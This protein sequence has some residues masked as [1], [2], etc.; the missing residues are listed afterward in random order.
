MFTLPPRLIPGDEFIANF[1]KV[2]ESTQF[3]TAFFNSLWLTTLVVLVQA[4]PGVAG[5]LRLR[6]ASFS[7]A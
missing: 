2:L 5:G 3:G 1:T 7:G 6:Q 4:L